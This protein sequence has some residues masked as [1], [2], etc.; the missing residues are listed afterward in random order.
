MDS[1]WNFAVSKKVFS[2]DDEEDEDYLR[3]GKYLSEFESE[4]EKDKAI[5][6]LGLDGIKHI[7]LSKPEFDNL[8]GYI[9]D[10]IYFVTE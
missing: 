1:N 7:I 4:E 8:D 6:N 10:T 5:K 3:R 2:S 9:K